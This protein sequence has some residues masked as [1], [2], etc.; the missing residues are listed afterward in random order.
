MLYMGGLGTPEIIIISMFTFF[1]LVLMLWA[2]VDVLQS[3]FKDGT[4][5]LL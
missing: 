4:T 2:L 5:K 1:P 3:D